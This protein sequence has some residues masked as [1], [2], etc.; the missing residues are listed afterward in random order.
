MKVTGQAVFPIVG[1]SDPRPR[2]RE[3]FRI[4]AAA[5]PAAAARRP[6]GRVG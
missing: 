5:A 4:A 6:S 1:A 2:R 3:G